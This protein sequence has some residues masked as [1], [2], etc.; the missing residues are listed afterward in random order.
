MRCGLIGRTGDFESSSR[1]SSPFVSA[2]EIMLLMIVLL[3]LSRLEIYPEFLM[4][5]R[6]II[7]WVLDVLIESIILVL[8]LS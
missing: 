4:T 6:L 3:V 7:Y 1:G 5:K 2:E 8:L